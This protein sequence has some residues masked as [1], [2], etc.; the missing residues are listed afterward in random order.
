M[1]IR[2]TTVLAWLSGSG[3]VVSLGAGLGI[4]G[5]AGAYTAYYA[6]ATSYLSNE[7]E[8]CVNCHI[9]R[10]V[11]DSWQKAPHHAVAVCNDCHLPHD[12][13]GKWVAKAEN[14]FNHSKAFT[15][16]NFHEPIRI[17][18]KNTAILERNCQDCHADTVHQMT[19]EVRQDDSLGCLHCH[20]D[21]GHGPRR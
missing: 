9:M 14:G 5:G 7:P 1:Q 15:L 3:F 6:N 13:L 11:Y 17:H 18:A 20:A 16:Q 12:F 8:A 10:E 21:I 4:L 2:L 19:T